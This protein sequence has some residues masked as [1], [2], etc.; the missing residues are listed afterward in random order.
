MFIYP[1]MLVVIISSI[2]GL[3]VVAKADGG[4]VGGGR[5]QNVSILFCDVFFY[6]R[7]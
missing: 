4:V 6:I 2:V 5:R 3:P 1:W 7:I